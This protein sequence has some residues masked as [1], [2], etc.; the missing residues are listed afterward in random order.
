MIIVFTTPL[1]AE[2]VSIS[3]AASLAPS[4]NIIKDMYQKSNPEDSLVF[5][6]A[7]SSVLARQIEYGAPADLYLSA[8]EKWVNYLQ[9][10]NKLIIDSIKPLITNQLV[11]AKRLSDVNGRIT[12]SCYDQNITKELISNIAALKKNIVV[13]DMQHVPL[14]IYSKQAL[15][16]TK[17]YSQIKTQLIPTANA[18]SA[19]AFL[20]QGQVEYAFLYYTDAIN[21][22][23]VEIVCIIPSDFHDQISYYLSKVK[24]LRQTTQ[25][26][27]K[28]IHDFYLFLQED[29]VK[30]VF[31]EQGFLEYK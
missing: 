12:Q 1:Q 14:G 21:S 27:D 9:L 15:Q 30:H 18:R 22:K 8:N 26:E 16:A 3:A 31:V 2:T 23:K 10:K 4:L 17:Q 13:A 25:E 19:L 6:Y 5:N 29:A 11:V 20:E 7:S 28:A 24:P